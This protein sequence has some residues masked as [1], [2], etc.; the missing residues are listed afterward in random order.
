MKTETNIP[1][2]KLAMT[3]KP[4]TIAFLLLAAASI[5]RAQNQEARERQLLT[6]GEPSIVSRDYIQEELKLSEDQTRK[7]SEKL[8]DYL[9]ASDA[10]EKLWVFL[11]E[12][13]NPEQFTR[14]RQLELQHEGPPALFRPEIAKELKITDE[15]RNQFM[16]LIQDMQMKIEPLM[17]EA[18]SGGNPEEIRPK[19]IKL[20]QDCQTTMEVLMSDAQKAQWK[21]MIG[22]PF[23]TLRHH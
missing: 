17:K 22:A 13:L 10:R 8:P 18:K 7:L 16:G 23:D 14:L 19:V 4:I 11:Q 15:Q 20:R 5:A 1:T 6:L 3:I 21:E 2:S 12:T 9:K